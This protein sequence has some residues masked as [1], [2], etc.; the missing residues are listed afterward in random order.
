MKTYGDTFAEWIEV[1]DKVGPPVAVIDYNSRNMLPVAD[2]I[3]TL[4]K[5]RTSAVWAALTASQARTRNIII[6]V[7]IATVIIGLALSV[8]IGSSIARPLHGLAEAMK[9]LANGDTSGAIP[10]TRAG[11]EIGD[12][13]RTVIVFRDNIIERDRLTSDQANSAREKEQRGESVAAAIAAFRN[14]IKPRWKTCAAR[15]NGWNRRRPS[16]TTRPMR[17]QPNRKRPKPA[18]TPRRKT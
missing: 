3:A 7:A 2:E 14:S 10:A 17:S 11:D 9:R 6:G 12:M 8:L 1:T 13:A 15:R 4:A 5:S 16:S 18:S